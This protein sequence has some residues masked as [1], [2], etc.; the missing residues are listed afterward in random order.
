MSGTFAP[1]KHYFYDRNLAFCEDLT[2]TATGNVQLASA[3]VIYQIG[4]GRKDGVWLINITALP[5]A[6]TDDVYTF[7]L[8]GSDSV[9]FASGIHILASLT[10][11]TTT[12]KVDVTT[13]VPWIRL[14]ITDVV[15]LYEKPFNNTKYAGI[16]MNGIVLDYVMMRVVMAGTSKSVTFDSWLSIE[17]E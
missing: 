7:Y 3:D 4:P 5:L 12:Y 10:V 9:T 11:A 13:G 8:L 17:S 1:R 14:G 16:P 15:G 2:L 6:D